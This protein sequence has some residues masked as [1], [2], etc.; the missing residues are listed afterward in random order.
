M[1]IYE[2]IT[3][4][5]DGFFKKGMKRH[6]FVDKQQHQLARIN[7]SKISRALNSLPMYF[8]NIY[9]ELVSP[10]FREHAAKISEYVKENN[11]KI[12]E[13]Y[14]AFRVPYND[15]V[16]CDGVDL[17]IVSSPANLV[18]NMLVFTPYIGE[19][20]PYLGLYIEANLNTDMWKVKEMVLL[21]HNALLPKKDISAVTYDD[22]RKM[23][24][25]L[26]VEKLPDLFP[27]VGQVI[28]NF[29]IC[30]VFSK[31]EG[32]YTDVKKVTP[33][34]KPISSRPNVFRE[35][36]INLNHTKFIMDRKAQRKG[37]K[38]TH[39]SD[40]PRM[41]KYLRHERYSQKGTLPVQYDIQGKPYYYTV[42]VDP[43]TRGKE[44]PRK[45]DSIKYKL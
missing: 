1:D 21:T 22:L 19:E 13:V 11:I 4:R 18:F 34:V 43:F 42:E 24:D 39:Q 5:L 29:I 9:D 7:A 26:C 33:G 15:F 2:R 14:D 37:H 45:E 16:L 44:L 20:Q 25:R 10:T 17:Y 30:Y 6:S 32:E 35:I 36:D 23:C 38:L 28:H 27:R 12:D 8:V 40:M 3:T 41:L 31:F